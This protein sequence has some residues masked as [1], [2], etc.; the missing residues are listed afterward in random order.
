MHAESLSSAQARTRGCR[1]WCDIERC[2]F[3]RMPLL[4][5]TIY[6]GER[7]CNKVESLC[8][9]AITL[10]WHDRISLGISG[11]GTESARQQS[12]HSRHCLVGDKI[13]VKVFEIMNIETA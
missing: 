6:K 8:I 4:L 5:L 2:E 13:G 10:T 7:N 11:K 3:N 12:Y 1:V 9:V